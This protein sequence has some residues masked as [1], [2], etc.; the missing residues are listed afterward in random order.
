[1]AKDIEKRKSTD[2]ETPREQQERF[3]RPRTSVSEYDDRVRI[4]MDVP[5]VNRDHLDISYNRG[6]LTITGRRETWD[7]EKMNACYCERFDGG[8]RRVFAL[9][10]TLDPEKI[11]AKLS[12]GVLELTI[13]KKEAVKPKKIEVK[14][15]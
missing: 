7:R 3:I 6:E 5:G 14:S 4:T 12:N 2:M 15:G 8:Y 11:D 9:D 1:M 13:P 10:E